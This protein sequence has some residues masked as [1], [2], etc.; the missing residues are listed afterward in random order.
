MVPDLNGLRDRQIDEIM[1]FCR[2]IAAS[3]RITASC[4]CGEYMLGITEG[5]AGVRVLLI[6]HDFAPRLMNYAK[7]LGDTNLSILAVDEWVFERD[8]D[9]GFLGEALASELIFPYTPLAN[10]E[11][12][13]FQE[14]KLKKRLVAE[15][16]GNLVLDFPEFSYLFYIEPEYFM[17]EA[18][19]T[20]ARLY[21]PMMYAMAN[22]TEK[23]VADDKIKA[24]LRG[25]VQA[26]KRLEQDGTVYSSDDYVRMSPDFVAYACK[27]SVRFTSLFKTGQRTL[28]TSLLGIFP[29]ILN[30]LS[31]NKD[32]SVSLQRMRRSNASFDLQ[33]EDPENHVYVQTSTGLVPLTNRID[34]EDFAREVLGADKNTKVSVKSLGGILNDVFLITTH[35]K[36][37]ETKVVVKRFR[38][39]SNFKWFPLTLWSVGTRTFTVLGRSRLE[40]EC[41]ISQLL[42]S[43]GFCV[44]RLLHVSPPRRLVFME[45]VEGESLGKLIKNITKSK[46]EKELQE[47]LQVFEQVG[48]LFARVHELRIAL[49][50]TKPENILIRKDGKICIVDFEQAERN[51]DRAWDL[52]EFVYYSGHYMPPFVDVGPMVKMAEAFLNGYLKAGGDARTIRNAGNAKYTKVFSVFTFPNIMLALSNACKNVDKL[53]GE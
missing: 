29:G 44:P 5:K 41:A 52:A 7:A 40:K 19:L 33:V 18:M 6:I 32:L 36:D 1:G 28:F 42:Y 53:E 48:Q 46:N 13:H 47:S 2:H 25:Y 4:L 10:G 11:Y 12:L 49:G 23:G 17:Y 3:A 14:I 43:K 37:K 31:Q 35:A 27:R 21:P 9:K 51:G 50:D 45:Y 30:F 8:V 15:M 26:L 24:V 39:W 22:L 20:R 16:L 38:D 34:I